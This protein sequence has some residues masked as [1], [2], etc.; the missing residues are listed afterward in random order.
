MLR[1]LIEAADA[2]LWLVFWI[3]GSLYLIW[4]LLW[5]LGLR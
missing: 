2:L 4:L 1:H 3:A 5:I